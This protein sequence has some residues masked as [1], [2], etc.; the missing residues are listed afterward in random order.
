MKL[1]ELIAEVGDEN[2]RF[3]YLASSFVKASNGRNGATVTFATDAQKA[4]ELMHSAVSW[5]KPEYV[6][7]VVWIPRNKIPKELL[8]GV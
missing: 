2:V 1:S 7:L 8:D 4:V 5:A 3:Q 6:G